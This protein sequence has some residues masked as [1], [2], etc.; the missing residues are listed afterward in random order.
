MVEAMFERS[1]N[2][3]KQFQ[4]QFKF[5]FVGEKPGFA[6]GNF[7]AMCPHFDSEFCNLVKAL[8][9]FW[10]TTFEN[11]TLK[12]YQSFP[13]PCVYTD[14][15]FLFWTASILKTNGD[16]FSKPI[17][18]SIS[19][20]P[21]Q[22]PIHSQCAK[23]CQFFAYNINFFEKQLYK[24][25]KCQHQ[26]E[27]QDAST[28]PKTIYNA[29]HLPK[30]IQTD[31]VNSETLRRFETILYGPHSDAF[32]QIKNISRSGYRKLKTDSDLMSVRFVNEKK[33]FEK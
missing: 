19:T 6:I 26:T 27:C 12:W 30:Q 9:T 17:W 33:I 1:P 16:V 22:K 32:C 28:C 21:R 2:Y 13:V 7:Y 20:V 31:L 24:T 18:Q 29:Q 23:D 5:L 25:N 10:L 4:K 3:F 15:K 8:S 11:D 14:L